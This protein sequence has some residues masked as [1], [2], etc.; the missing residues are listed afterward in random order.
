VGGGRAFD[1]APGRGASRPRAARE[2]IRH[3][4]DILVEEL[5]IA[6]ALSGASAVTE[7]KSAD[8]G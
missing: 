6:M 4:L 2:A 8:S 3:A 1:Y 7:L 5:R